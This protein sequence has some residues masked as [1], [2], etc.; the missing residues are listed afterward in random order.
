MPLTPL[1]PIVLAA[2]ALLL[3]AS[4]AVAQTGED[5]L[6]FGDRDPGFSARTLGLAGAAVGGL[7]DWGAAVVNP[8]S[9]ALARRSHVTGSLDLT[10][11]LSEPSSGMGSTARATRV[12]PGHAAYVASLPASRG[13]FVVGLGYNRT[14]SLDRR[15]FFETD[16]GTGQIYESGWLGELSGVAALEVTPRLYFGASF[17][18]AFGEYAFT[19]YL[20]QG[21]SITDTWFLESQLRGFNLRAGLI[22]QPVSGLRL[23]LSVDTPT[24]LHAEES[25]GEV[26]AG[27]GRS[28]YTMQSPWRISTGAVYQFENVLLTADVIF[29]DW[30]QTRLRPSHVFAE[31][32]IDIYDLYRE[33][34]D[35]R[36]GAEYD[37]GLGAVRTG[38]AIAQDPLRD[39]L[40]ADRLRQTF[41][42]GFS[43]YFRRGIT[44]DVGL[45]YTAF[46]DQTFLDGQRV[47]EQVGRF[48]GLVGLHLNL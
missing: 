39:E 42:S 36:L 1:R 13:A 5:I 10:S 4:P 17:N 37:F 26:R 3:F 2:L 12:M 44:V 40:Q 9:L 45:A 34:L 38:Y 8:A 43:F 47:T 33:T 19:E 20:G 35:A 18:A 30:S 14:T 31:E 27:P 22:G 28:S 7:G 11:T 6:R 46:A 24:W 25:F 41:A 23:G 21:A 48:R 15:L 29:A 32:N 16:A